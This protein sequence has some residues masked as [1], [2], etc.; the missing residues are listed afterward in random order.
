MKKKQNKNQIENKILIS[1][2]TSVSAL[3]LAFLILCVTT[4]CIY[5]PTYLERVLTHWDLKVSDY[6]IFP[7]RI[8][9]KSEKPY[10]YEKNVN[11]DL[12]NIIVGYSNKKNCLPNL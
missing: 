9:E 2:I 11:T 8:I 3:L 1:I 4:M 5:S 7:E 12:S 6:K 10:N